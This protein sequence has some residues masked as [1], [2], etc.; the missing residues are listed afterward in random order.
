MGN[1]EKKGRFDIYMGM[2]GSSFLMAPTT[3]IVHMGCS[4]GCDA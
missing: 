1:K 4:L 2:G 3:I